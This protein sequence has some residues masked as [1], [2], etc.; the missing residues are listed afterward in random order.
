[1]QSDYIDAVVAVLDEND[2]SLPDI[3]IDYCGTPALQRAYAYLRSRSGCLV[4]TNNYYWSKSRSAECEF[5]FDD[6]PIQAMIDGDAEGFHVVF[7]EMRSPGGHAV[8]DLGAGCYTIDTLSL[9]Y[10]MGP[11]WDAAAVVGLFELLRDLSSLAPRVDIK[12]SCNIFDEHDALL[13][14]YRRWLIENG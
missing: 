7:G 8:P 12:H 11:E 9:D 14:G 10:R 13:G 2:G 3:E 6:D 4:S 1:M 5:G